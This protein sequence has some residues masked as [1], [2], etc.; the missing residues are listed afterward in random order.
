[1]LRCLRDKDVTFRTVQVSLLRNRINKVAPRAFLSSALLVL[2]ST[3]VN[4]QRN[5]SRASKIMCFRRQLLSVAVYLSL[6]LARRRSVRRRR[7]DQNSICTL[8]KA[9]YFCVLLLTAFTNRPQVSVERGKAKYNTLKPC[10][11]YQSIFAWCL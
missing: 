4:A 5:A 7:G 9:L 3:Q 6:W 1:M 8:K 10:L 11:A 2:R